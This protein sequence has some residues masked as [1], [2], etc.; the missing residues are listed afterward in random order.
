[1][2]LKVPAHFDGQQVVLDA[3][4]PG[5][6]SSGT[7]LEVRSADIASV[8]GKDKRND[9]IEKYF[10]ITR[11]FLR[12]TEGEPRAQGRTWKREDAYE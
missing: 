5:E 7:A 4:V 12:R 8:G 9:L 3:P 11:E 6:W 2:V 1:M 10:A